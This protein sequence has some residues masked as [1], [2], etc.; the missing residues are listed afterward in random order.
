MAANGSSMA[1]SANAANV[2]GWLMANVSSVAKRSIS[3]K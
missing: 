2:N 1:A 3:A